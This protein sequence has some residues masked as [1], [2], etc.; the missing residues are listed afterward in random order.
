MGLRRRRYLQEMTSSGA[1]PAVAKP[2]VALKKGFP[3]TVTGIV[4]ILKRRRRR[5]LKRSSKQ[6]SP[7]VPR[8]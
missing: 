1:I 2:W 7:L 4:D 6:F 5:M 3:A 8:I